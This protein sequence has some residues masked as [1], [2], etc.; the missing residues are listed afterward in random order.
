MIKAPTSLAVNFSANQPGVGRTVV[1]IAT[2]SSTTGAAP[3]GTVSFADVTGG[4]N[5]ALGS[6][7]L[8]GGQAGYPA[9]FLS[10]GPRTIQATYSGDNNFLGSAP[11]QNSLTVVPAMTAATIA[12][13]RAPSVYGQAV[14]LS[15]HVT[16]PS[17]G[18]PTGNITFLDG[19]NSL[20]TV[21]SDGSGVAQLTTTAL[22]AG[23]HSLTAVFDDPNHNFLGTTSGTLSQTVTP[24][25]TRTEIVSSA[26]PWDP[27]KGTLQ[28]IATVAGQFGGAVTGSVDFTDSSVGALGSAVLDQSG[29]ATLPSGLLSNGLHTITATYTPDSNNLGST[30]GLMQLINPLGLATPTITFTVSANPVHRRQQ[31]TLN[32]IVSGASGTPTGVVRLVDDDNILGG[33]DI[34]LD[35]GGAASLDITDHFTIGEHNIMLI[36]EG[37]GTY[38]GDIAFVKVD[39]TPKPR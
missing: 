6:A 37:D 19:A 7:T 10:T 16:A 22:T 14:T 25:A 11:A 21:A 34:T 9:S 12:S 35:G 26:N 33:T 39:R 30:D 17:G 24:A 1:L 27:S 32:I 29:T 15:A 5:V 2:A 20:G 8:V 3:T 13:N 4:G 28:L 23:L 38:A 31:A 36:Y 18:Q